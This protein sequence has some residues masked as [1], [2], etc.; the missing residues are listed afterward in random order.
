MQNSTMKWNIVFTKAR[1][2]NERTS[3]DIQTGSRVAVLGLVS[4][5]CW[6]WCRC[7]CWCWCWCWC[8]SVCRVNAAGDAG[9]CTVSDDVTGRSPR[10]CRNRVFS[11]CWR[12]VSVSWPDQTHQ[13]NRYSHDRTSFVKYARQ[14]LTHSILKDKNISYFYFLCAVIWL[15]FVL[16]FYGTGSSLSRIIIF[17]YLQ[18]T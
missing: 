11:S 8:I 5:W 9:A 6:W 15:Y 13:H 14:G 7:W 1:I 17:T 3:D 2:S 18:W 10:S 16:A 12:R 4:R